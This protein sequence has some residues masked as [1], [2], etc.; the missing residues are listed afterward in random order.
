MTKSQIKNRVSIPDSTVGAYI[1]KNYPMTKPGSAFQRVPP[2][3]FK[4]QVWSYLATKAINRSFKT[5][6]KLIKLSKEQIETHPA[7]AEIR[8]VIRTNP[9]LEKASFY[10]PCRALKH[11]RKHNGMVP[12]IVKRNS[13]PEEESVNT[14]DSSFE[15]KV[16]KSTASKTISKT[17]SVT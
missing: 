3:A 13:E 2:T 11:A 5:S 17:A 16:P 15:T 10:V 1:A 6:Q 14:D 9:A 7:L 12:V 8:R 4:E